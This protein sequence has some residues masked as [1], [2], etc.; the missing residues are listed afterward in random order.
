MKELGKQS[1]VREFEGGVIMTKT[2]IDVASADYYFKAQNLLRSRFTPSFDSKEFAM[3]TE[4]SLEWLKNPKNLSDFVKANDNPGNRK[5][6]PEFIQTSQLRLNLFLEIGQEVE[7]NKESSQYNVPVAFEAN[8]KEFKTD[9][10]S[11]TEHLVEDL[12]KYNP[13]IGNP[14]LEAKNDL[15]LLALASKFYETVGYAHKYE[16]A[17]AILTMLFKRYWEVLGVSAKILASPEM[18]LVNRTN[19]FPGA[20]IDVSGIFP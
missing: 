12:I 11:I 4:N 6:F 10:H 14:E 5:F 9:L 17:D 13:N 8:T 16:A 15:R 18:R 7:K 2:L 1:L 3:A 19:R 20:R